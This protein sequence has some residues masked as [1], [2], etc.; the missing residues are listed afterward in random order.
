MN[1]LRV[2]RAS[3]LMIA[4]RRM[5]CRE[6]PGARASCRIVLVK[7]HRSLLFLSL[8]C[9][10]LVSGCATNRA[11]APAETS[12]SGPNGCLVGDPVPLKW[13][14]YALLPLS[15]PY[16]VLKEAQHTPGV[17]IWK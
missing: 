17:V 12:R 3:R 10:F 6:L 5:V 7:A 16:F 4:T 9:V 2:W 14:E 1:L 13:W 8:A 15:V 11:P